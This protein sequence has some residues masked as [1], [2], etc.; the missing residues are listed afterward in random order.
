MNDS[1]RE[2]QF[3]AIVVGAGFAGLY[4]L[5]RLRNLGL[6]V[7]VFE[8]GGGVGGTWFWNRYPGA[9]CDIESLEYSYSFSEELQQ[10]WQ[11]PD[12]YGF[13][14]EIL[15]YL[16]HVADRFDLRRDIEFN[17]RVTTAVFDPGVARWTVSF[18]HGTSVTA[19]FCV[20]ACGNLSAPRIPDIPGLKDFRGRWYHTARWPV[21]QVDFSGLNV[22]VVGTGAT[23]VQVIPWIAREA[24]HLHVFQR[25]ANYSVP[26]RNGPLDA[27]RERAHKANYRQRR[28]AALLTSFG[29]AGYPPPTQ[30]ALGVSD[31]ERLRTYEA[32][33]AEGLA[34]G[35]LSSY[36]DLMT[37]KAA[38]DT[39]AEFVRGKIRAT[40]RDPAVAELL[41]PTD[42]PLGSR[43]LCLDSGYYETFNRDNVSLVD[44][45]NEPI[46]AITADGLATAKREYRLDAIVFATGFDAMTG[47]LR[48]IDIRNGAGDNL[49]GRWAADP[50]SYLGL[51]IA[52]FPDMFLVTGP[53]SPS[54]KAQMVVAIEHHVNWI[55]ECIEHLRVRGLSSIEAQEAPQADW[56]RHVDQVAQGTLFPLA[57]SWYY[58]K[59]GPGSQ[60]RFIPYVGGFA[61][62]RAKCA[63]VAA[64]GYEGFTLKE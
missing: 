27:G 9:R 1:G 10:Q 48:A 54:V 24:A 47:A 46:T 28:E 45:R 64:N 53:G 18:D 30:S 6:R 23:G 29:V 16:D 20:M 19:R 37:S 2:A 4:A 41:V 34:F 43:R 57:D 63:E 58:S 13:Q 52:G 3:D 62:Y 32:K 51:M 59:G 39:A 40:V 44:A 7:R 8:A 17:T 36:T 25:T 33:W 12:R 49:A 60:R 14:P 38:N 22:G 35:L 50:A 56:V 11:W 42:H 15:R 61:R 26:A 21:T 31:E 5:Y 55:A